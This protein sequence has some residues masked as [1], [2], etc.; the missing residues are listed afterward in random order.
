MTRA[1][2]TVVKQ[3]RSAVSTSLPG[4]VIWGGAIPVAPGDLAV[5]DRVQVL[6]PVLL[7]RVPRVLG[8]LPGFRR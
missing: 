7:R 2:N 8:G 5:G 3:V 4:W 1:E 6:D